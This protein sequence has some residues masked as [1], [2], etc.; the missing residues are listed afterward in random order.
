MQHYGMHTVIA[1]LCY[2]REEIR[3]KRVYPMFR[4]QQ[5]PL[6]RDASSA[7]TGARHGVLKHVV[8]RTTF[9]DCDADRSAQ[10]AVGQITSE[11][12]LEGGKLARTYSM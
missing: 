11:R 9:G 7:E 2:G 4:P 5:T 1:R 6:R 8:P 12:S 3:D 10:A